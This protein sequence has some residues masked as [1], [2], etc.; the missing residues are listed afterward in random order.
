MQISNTTNFTGWVRAHLKIAVPHDTPT[1]RVY[2]MRRGGPLTGWVRRTGAPKEM[3][4]AHDTPRSLAY[5]AFGVFGTIFRELEWKTRILSG[6]AVPKFPIASYLLRGGP[7]AGPRRRRAAAAAHSALEWQRLHL[8]AR[9]HAGPN[10]RYAR[11]G[12][13]V[14]SIHL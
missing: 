14:R 6:I 3:A 11:A 8:R 4:A 9:E 5:D 12:S 7:R 10:K 1:P 2:F 13:V